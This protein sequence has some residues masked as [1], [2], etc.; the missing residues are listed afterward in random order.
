MSKSTHDKEAKK[1]GF[2]YGGSQFNTNLTFAGL[3][4]WGGWLAYN[5]PTLNGGYIQV[6]LFVI[7]FGG[8]A[9]GSAQQFMPNIAEG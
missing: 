9:A 5:D 6:A 3:Q 7:A 1:A 8:F 2:A 4:L